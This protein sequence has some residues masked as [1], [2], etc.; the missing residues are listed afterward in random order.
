MLCRCQAVEVRVSAGSIDREAPDLAEAHMSSC[1]GPASG[2]IDYVLVL[3]RI[4]GAWRVSDVVE[5]GKR[6][7]GRP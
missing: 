2:C 5:Q 1:D 7:Q 3:R 4:A 6:S